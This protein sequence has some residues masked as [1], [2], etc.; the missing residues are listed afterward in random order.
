MRLAMGHANAHFVSV[1]LECSLTIRTFENYWEQSQLF[2]K[3]ANVTKL[4]IFLS[5]V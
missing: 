1:N 4:L 2:T 3:Q 5:K